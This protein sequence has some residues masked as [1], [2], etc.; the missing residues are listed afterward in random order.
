[1]YITLLANSCICCRFGFA[2]SKTLFCAITDFSFLIAETRLL[3]SETTTVVV[4]GS[5][6]KPYSAACASALKIV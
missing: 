5:V 4:M 1:L 3:E 6:Y 2:G